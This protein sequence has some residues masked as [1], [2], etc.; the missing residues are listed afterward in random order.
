MPPSGPPPHGDGGNGGS[1]GGYCSGGGGSGGSGGGYGSEGRGGGGHGGP[2]SYPMA[3]NP[4]F[5][6]P[7]PLTKPDIKAYEKL[8]D[9]STFDEWY[10]DAITL[11][12]AHRVDEIFDPSFRPDMNNYDEV[13]L[14]KA[15]Q[16]FF[17]AVL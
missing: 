10:K 13:M 9:I 1:G 5:W 12:Q 15:K 11:A 8:K 2:P 6:P 3:H 16:T 14:F 17:Y 4:T 7:K